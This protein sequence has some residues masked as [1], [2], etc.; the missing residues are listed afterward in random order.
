MKEFIRVNLYDASQIKALKNFLGDKF[1]SIELNSY[2]IL[3]ASFKSR[4]LEYGSLYSNEF[5]VKNSDGNF[6]SYT[7][8]EFLDEFYFIKGFAG[9]DEGETE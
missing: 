4:N 5:I 6:E 2:G 3:Y 9:V 1:I 7:T 8:S